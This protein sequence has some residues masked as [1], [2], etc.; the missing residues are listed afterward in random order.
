MIDSDYRSACRQEPDST[1]VRVGGSTMRILISVSCFETLPAI[2][3]EITLLTYLP[4]AEDALQLYGSAT[5]WNGTSSRADLRLRN[6]AAARGRDPEAAPPPRACGRPSIG[7][8]TSSSRS[9]AWA[10]ARLAPRVEL[11]E[12]FT[13]GVTV[14]DPAGSGNAR[15]APGRDRGDAAAAC[16]RWVSRG[17]GRL[18][19]PG[20]A[21]GMG[22][23][24]TVETVI[25]KAL[26]QGSSIGDDK[27]R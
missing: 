23:N 7:T 22:A 3:R 6:R 1:V 15:R 16:P 26:Q 9:P 5:R 27:A 20:G 4:R 8:R 25:R 2:G 24:A 17:A 21:S 13:P 11:R 14:D 10:E 18:G 19:C 12:K